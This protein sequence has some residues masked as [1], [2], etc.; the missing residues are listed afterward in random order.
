MPCFKKSNPSSSQQ[1]AT[2]VVPVEKPADAFL[3]A[4]AERRTVYDLTSRTSIPD[5]RIVEIVQRAGELTRFLKVEEHN[6]DDDLR[7]GA[8]FYTPPPLSTRNRTAPSSFSAGSIQGS[9][10]LSPNLWRRFFP[11][12]NSRA[13]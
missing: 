8:Q 5:E 3:K 1:Q 6:E 4:L 13:L 11:R 2:A 12:S 9:G 10:T 7:L